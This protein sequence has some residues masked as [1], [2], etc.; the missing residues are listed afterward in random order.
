MPIHGKSFFEALVDSRGDSDELEEF[1]RKI[2]AGLGIPKDLLFGDPQSMAS[3][4]VEREVQAASQH[5]EKAILFVANTRSVLRGNIRRN[6]EMIR[7]LEVNEE[8]VSY[9]LGRIGAGFERMGVEIV[10][11]FVG[12]PY[13]TFLYDGEDLFGARS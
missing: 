13:Y 1:S 8:G 9:L 6:L 10:E 11:N 5:L 2:Y 7:K 4:M 12:D 3:S